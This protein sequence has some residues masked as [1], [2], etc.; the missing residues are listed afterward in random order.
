M[1]FASVDQSVSSGR[2]Y[3]FYRFT[4]GAQAWLYTDAA[5]PQTHPVFGPATPA[6]IRRTSSPIGKETQKSPITLTVPVDFPIAALFGGA[7]PATAIWLT[8]IEGHLG[9]T[10][11]Q[12]QWA[13]RV[14]A[15]TRRTAGSEL[16]CDPADK[17]IGRTPLRA[18][19]GPM[20]H[21]RL[22]GQGPNGC[23]ASEA[24]HTHEVTLSGVAAEVLTA[25]DLG[26]QP[27]GFWVGA[28]CYVP[29]L[30]A[31][32]MVVGHTGATITLWA[33]IPGL[34]VGDLVRLIEGCDHLWKR[35]DGSWGDCHARFGNGINFGGD[36]WVAPGKNPF[37]TLV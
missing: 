18:T 11:L 16:T 35:S 10:E 9:E 37:K 15:C 19:T 1:T 12:T 36:P 31:R 2:P 22:Y 4:R 27:D 7:P 20:C 33:A 14:R 13:G 8:I 23:L 25:T 32:I 26:L 30:D 6:S 21:K 34:Q 24:A 17:V 29:R 3:Q 28:E 5:I